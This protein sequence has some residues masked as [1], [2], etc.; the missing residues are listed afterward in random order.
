MV[1]WWVNGWRR[2]RKKKRTEGKRPGNLGPKRH[3]GWA[4]HHP[5]EAER[6]SSVF[7]SMLHNWFGGWREICTMIRGMGTA[8]KC[9]KWVWG[10]HGL[11]DS[12]SQETEIKARSRKGGRGLLKWVVEGSL[13]RMF[14]PTFL[15]VHTNYK[16][17]EVSLWYFHTWT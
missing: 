9:S 8:G 15:L 17:W 12:L 3:W 6:H 16:I 13:P 2:Q 1:V 7:Q 5:G 11:W 4:G 10:K 14:F